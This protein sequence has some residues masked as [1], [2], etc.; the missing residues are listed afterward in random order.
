MTQQNV[1]HEDVDD[2]EGVQL[3]AGKEV[4]N[5]GKM[6]ILIEIGN[7]VFNSGASFSLLRILTNEI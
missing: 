6:R 7:G 1:V 4:Q 5:C 2:N 3:S